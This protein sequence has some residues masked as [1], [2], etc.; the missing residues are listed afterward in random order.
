MAAVSV[1][2]LDDEVRDRLRVRA[3]RHGRSME[4]EIRTIL[5]DAVASDEEQPDLFLALLEHFGSLGG[6]DLDV[7]V[8]TASVREPVFEP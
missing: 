8:R 4:A 3:A 7:P 2:D 1:R 6:V 5:T